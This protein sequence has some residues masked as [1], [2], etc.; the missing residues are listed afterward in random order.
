M[1]NTFAPVGAALPARRDAL[2]IE[3]ADG[4]SIPRFDGGGESIIAP[5][6]QDRLLEL[7]E[8][9]QLPADVR[10]TLAGALQG[11]LF[12]Q[13]LLFQAMIDTWPR[14]QKALAEIKRAARKAPWQVKAWANRGEKPTAGAEALA[15]EVESAVW[16]MRPDPVR[17]LKGFEG[18]VEELAMG[19]FL[20]HQVMEVHWARDGSTWRPASAKVSPPRFYGYSQTWDG[21]DRLML[22][23]TGGMGALQLEDFPEH[24]FLIAVNGGHSGH[25]A[26]SAPLRA[27][28]TYWLAAVYGLKWLIQF[29]QLCGVPFRWAE[30]AGEP[31][32]VKVTQML[33]K[34]GSA[35]WGA[36]PAGTKLNFV[37]SRRSAEQLPTKVLIDLAD[38]Q[39]DIFI[40]GQ[41]LTSSAG[42]KGSQA[43]G[44]VHETVRQDVIEGVCDF[45][46]EVLTHQLVPSLVTLNH[47][48]ARGDMP[49]I[50][51]VFE[52]A[53]D[54]KAKAERMEA[55]KR[56]GLPVERQWAYDDLGVPMPAPGAELL[57]EEAAAGSD[58]VK[59]DPAKGPI[60][61]EDDKER[62]EARDGWE[63]FAADSGTLGIPRA[64]MPQIRAGDRA[65]MVQ[66]LRA[67]GITSAEETVDPAALMAT[68]A[69]Y[70]P[71]K[72][73]A[74]RGYRGG[75]R[76]ILISQDDHVV[77]GHH[78]WLAALEKGEPIRV[79]RL[80][81]PVTRILMM[82]HRMPSTRVEASLRED[83]DDGRPKML[84]VDRLSSAVLE[85]LTGV[86]ADWLG[87]VRPFFDRLA[88]LAMAK[89]VTDDDFLAA[90]EKAGR[91]LPELFDVLDKQALQEAFDDAIG[92]AMLAGSTSRYER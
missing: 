24:R 32:R 75:S 13:Q 57:F 79:I 68:Q 46:G 14:L 56:L 44:T 30:Y 85:G 2:R 67:R 62:L 87:P 77:D 66:F 55:L 58:G 90:L 16:S 80:M 83:L 4:G 26:V 1:G 5:K 25:A 12:R 47:G 88:A 73:A 18:M 49:G 69:E 38:E 20:G 8:R 64:E 81:A 9:E 78:Q 33:E 50:W 19:Y 84:T 53:K 40:L 76:A 54:E 89:Q 51:A 34:I 48:A 41:T 63:A 70:S 10:H 31:D 42:D 74:A 21:E 7:I 17:G 6:A 39:C 82:V 59:G 36:F 72:V 71:A 22:D 60:P 15:K 86:T 52:K 27:L 61:P 43:L 29:A 3:A 65:A 11:D 37:E 92:S 28:A 35:G 23:R 91:E 45:V